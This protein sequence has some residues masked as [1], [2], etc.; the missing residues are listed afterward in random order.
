MKNGKTLGIIPARGG[1]KRIPKKNIRILAGKPL[2]AWT[3]EV[4]RECGEM[5]RI[6]VSTD[7]AEIA[8]ISRKYGAEIPFSR[9]AEAAQDDTPDYVVYRHAVSWLKENDDFAPDIVVW[10]RPTSPL[11]NAEDIHNAIGIFK[12]RG[13]DCVRSVCE[14][15]QHPYWMKTIQNGYLVP[16]M[17]GCDEKEYYQRQTLPPV[18]RLNGAV[19]VFSNV[20][21]EKNGDLYGGKIHGYVMPVERSI[22]IDSEIDL[23]IAELL[24][25]KGRH[26]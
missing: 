15:E 5:D 2:I 10:L 16:L 24:L 22:D 7:D 4:A 25:K 23:A 21:V 12:D 17:D 19:D 13:A 9:P 11:R 1:S 14:V 8:D 18:Y 26:D 20:A 3:L 6:I